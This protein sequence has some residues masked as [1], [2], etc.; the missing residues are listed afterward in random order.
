M[1]EGKKEQGLNVA[2]FA[3]VRIDGVWKKWVEV[4]RGGYSEKGQAEKNCRFK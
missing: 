1:G 3:R 2:K 4:E